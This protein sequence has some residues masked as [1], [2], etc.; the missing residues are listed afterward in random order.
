MSP[1]SHRLFGQGLFERHAHGIRNRLGRGGCTVRV[2]RRFFGIGEGAFRADI[3]RNGPIQPLVIRRGQL[4][5]HHHPE[6]H[7]GQRVGRIGIDE[8][9]NLGWARQRDGHGVT[10]NLDGRGNLDIAIA[11][12]SVFKNGFTVIGPVWNSVDKRPHLVFGQIEQ[13]RHTGHDH[14]FAVFLKQTDQVALANRD[15]GKLSTHIASLKPAGADIGQNKIHH[16]SPLYPAVPYF[17]RRDA[18]A[19]GINLF[20]F[21]VIAGG[22][23]AANVGD[24]AF[25]DRPERELVLV[26]DRLIHAAVNNMRAAPG[27]V[28]VIEHI[29][30]MNI[31]AEIVGNGPQGRHQRA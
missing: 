10:N 23:G 30:R 6:I 2:R 31:V 3:N 16:I 26:E 18:Q 19:L 13:F 14:I 8:I 5:E 28:V 22:Y 25:A 4:G 12:S 15:R 27:G 1:G 21:G 7:P 11:V 29:P 20:G 17:Q 9:R 24:V